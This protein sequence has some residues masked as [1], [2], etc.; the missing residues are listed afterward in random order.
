MAD[1]FDPN[2]A[3]GEV[4]KSILNSEPVNNLLGPLTQSIGIILG[5]VGDIAR[6]YA[7]ENLTRIFTKWA[8]KRDGEPLNAE[9]FKRVL[10]LLRDVAMQSNDELQDRWATLLENIATATK[11]V[12][13]SFGQTLSQLTPEEARYLDRVWERVSAPKVYNF[14]KREGRDELSFANL[15]DI[16]NPALRAPGPAEMYVYR[17]RMSPE[18]IAAFDEMTNFELMLHDLERLRLLEKSSEYISERQHYVEVNGTEIPVSREGG[19]KIT[20][21][22]TQYGVNF[23]LAVRPNKTVK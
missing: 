3:A 21:S 5:Q 2:E 9:A 10:P 18:Q 7:D 23:I 11:G 19:M 15:L 12:L 17:S 13:P 16:Y 8:T 22:L 6:F 20:Y 1:S 4:A 14:G